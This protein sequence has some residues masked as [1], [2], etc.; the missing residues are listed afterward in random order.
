RLAAMLHESPEARTPLQIQIEV[1]G[2]RLALIAGMAVVVIVT[3]ELLR[4]VAWF[5]LVMEAIAIA[6]AAIPEGLPAVVTVTLAIGM[7]RMARQRA[8]VKR[9]ASVETL[10]CTTDI[11]SDKTGTLT[12]NQM[13]VREIVLH[14]GSRAVTGQ[15]Y[16][17]QGDIQGEASR[18]LDTLLRAGAL[19]NDSSV[20]DGAIA[21]DP[22]EAALCVL[23][24]KGGIDVDDLR[25]SEPRLAEVPF[26]AERKFS[27][28]LHSPGVMYVKGAPDV[29]LERCTKLLEAEGPVAL[30][31]AALERFAAANTHLAERGFRVLAVAMRDIG[32]SAPRDDGLF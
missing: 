3:L 2:R 18:A 27:A 17:M 30:D 9:M 7:H 26:E 15:G 4:G 19:C 10:G 29:L 24:A 31:A 21:G 28:T 20:R 1:L 14:D 16:G 13:T 22:T 5:E 25:R 11:C 32:A 23:A 8:I 6:V 12:M